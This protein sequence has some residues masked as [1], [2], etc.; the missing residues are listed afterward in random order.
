MKDLCPPLLAITLGP[1][2]ARPAVTT[3]RVVAVVQRQ[4]NLHEVVPNSVFGDESVVPLCLL[5]DGTEVTT[6]AVFHEDV[7]DASI[8]INVSIMVAYNV[9]VVEVFEDVSG[10]QTCMASVR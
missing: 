4:K 6:S 8:S 2:T 1:N 10:V 3:I 9:F 5:N 7:E